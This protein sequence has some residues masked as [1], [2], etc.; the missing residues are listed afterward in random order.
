MSQEIGPCVNSVV[1]FR[2]ATKSRPPGWGE[3]QPSSIS[4]CE[5]QVLMLALSEGNLG[6]YSRAVPAYSL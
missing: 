3:R 2:G 5:P 4:P 6:T 1:S